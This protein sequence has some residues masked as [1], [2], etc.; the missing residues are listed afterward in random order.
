MTPAQFS[1][2]KGIRIDRVLEIELLDNQEVSKLEGQ[3]L[4][5]ENMYKYMKQD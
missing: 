1:K 4:K 2:K 5:L 3:S